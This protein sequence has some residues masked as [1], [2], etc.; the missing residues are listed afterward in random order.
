MF[1][2]L[3]SDIWGL[4]ALGATLQ[5]LRKKYFFPQCEKGGYKPH[6]KPDSGLR[7]KT[8]FPQG[9]ENDLLELLGARK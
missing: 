1:L 9:L 2:K 8:V 5:A 6:R 4:E 3:R 7:E